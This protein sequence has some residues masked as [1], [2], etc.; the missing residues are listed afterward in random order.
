M[1]GILKRFWSANEISGSAAPSPLQRILG[2]AHGPEDTSRTE[3]RDAIIVHC[4][5]PPNDLFE[6]ESGGARY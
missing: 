5:R 3:V 4:K 6:V 1:H 2:V